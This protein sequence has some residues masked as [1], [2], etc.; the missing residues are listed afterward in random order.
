MA[1][2]IAGL[3]T[4]VFLNADGT[5]EIVLSG[6]KQK[7][8]SV[9]EIKNITGIDIGIYPDSIVTAKIETIL[10]VDFMDDINGL[11]PVFKDIIYLTE[12][13]PESEI[14]DFVDVVTL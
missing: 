10:P 8:S 2:I 11:D 12:L 3:G 9:T 1:S 5:I 13:I 14:I 7:G 6:K 4:H